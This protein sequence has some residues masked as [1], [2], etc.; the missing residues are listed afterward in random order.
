MNTIWILILF[1]GDSRGGVTA[2]EFSNEKSCRSAIV[3][4]QVAPLI[5]T[6]KAIC[7]PKEI[8]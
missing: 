1:Y 5:A 6:V 7:V 2:A 8:K 4:A 3:S